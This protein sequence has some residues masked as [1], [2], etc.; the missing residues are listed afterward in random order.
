MGRGAHG[1]GGKA[2]R[3]AARRGRPVAR[4]P[5]APRQFDPFPASERMNPTCSPSKPRTAAIPIL[6]TP[7]RTSCQRRRRQSPP[8][9]PAAPPGGRGPGGAPAAARQNVP[10]GTHCGRPA[11]PY[12]PSARK[13]P[14]PP[15]TDMP[16][17][18]PPRAAPQRSACGAAQHERRD[19]RSRTAAATSSP[20]PTLLNIL[21]GQSKGGRRLPPATPRCRS[22]PS[23]GQGRETSLKNIAKK[24]YKVN[25]RLM[26]ASPGK[27]APS[28]WPACSGH[29]NVSKAARSVRARAHDA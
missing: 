4:L 7:L 26:K 3:G 27:A 11:L 9:P 25:R 28:T 17:K 20:P 8:P 18:A 12:L 23:E 10:F 24:K 16:R 15:A 22:G 14:F 19:D 6:S 13:P 21:R 2:R 5:A 29:I 1:E